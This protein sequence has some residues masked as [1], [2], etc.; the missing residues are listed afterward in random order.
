M[1]LSSIK[2][3]E[4]RSATLQ[5][6]AMLR[7]LVFPVPK[8]SVVTFFFI[9]EPALTLSDTYK[10]SREPWEIAASA[11]FPQYRNYLNEPRM[12]NEA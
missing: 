9:F 7:L 5:L 12:H 2:N 4:H 10:V 6:N 1:F 8:D 3:N 11:I